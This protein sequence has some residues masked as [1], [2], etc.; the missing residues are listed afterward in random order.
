MDIVKTFFYRALG[1][2]TLYANGLINKIEIKY[3]FYENKNIKIGVKAGYRGLPYLNYKEFYGYEFG[4]TGLFGAF[5][6]KVKKIKTS[7]DV[8]ADVNFYKREKAWS[9]R[10][11]P[12]LL[13]KTK[14]KY[15]DLN[16]YLSI[17][18]ISTSKI[19]EKIIFRADFKIKKIKYL[20]DTLVK[21]YFGNKPIISSLNEEK[22]IKECKKNEEEGHN[23]Y[24]P[25]VG[26]STTYKI[27]L[28]K[29]NI[30]KILGFEKFKC[31]LNLIVEYKIFEKYD[32]LPTPANGYNHV[33]GKLDLTIGILKLKE[34]RF[35]KLGKLQIN[36]FNFALKRTSEY[37]IY[38]G[39]AFF[40]K[41]IF[42]VLVLKYNILKGL[43]LS[44]HLFKFEMQYKI[45]KIGIPV[46]MPINQEPQEPMVIMQDY[47]VFESLWMPSLEIKFDVAKYL[48]AKKKK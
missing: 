31:K 43:S 9:K 22:Y 48:V 32:D 38:K 41:Y 36:V 4:D 19:L 23:L 10:I 13:T 40:N 24:S 17:F 8:G 46:Q 18:S 21:I 27:C 37:F 6:T 12:V 29:M 26:I 47:L 44:L 20:E 25:I 39:K 5:T 14:L 15:F 34:S 30:F 33:Q 1:I 45:K 16:G 42:D 2:P 28:N 7:F 11:S 3:N 35:K